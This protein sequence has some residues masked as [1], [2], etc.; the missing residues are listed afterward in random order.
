[1]YDECD[2]V[3][4]KPVQTSSVSYTPP[5]LRKRELAALLIPTLFFPPV[6]FL[7]AGIIVVDQLRRSNAKHV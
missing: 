5:K 7:S 2:S 4:P 1:M 3:T 6:F